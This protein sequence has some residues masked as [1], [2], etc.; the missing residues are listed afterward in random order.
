LALVAG[1]ALVAG[2]AVLWWPNGEYRPIQ[3]GERG[4]VAD[5]F[6]TIAE[7][8][9]GR[10]G[11]TE[12]RVKELG[13]A[14]ARADESTGATVPQ[15]SSTT[16]PASGQSPTTTARATTRTTDEVRATTT[17]SPTSSDGPGTGGSDGTTP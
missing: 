17:T 13:G 2:L 7:V 8:P 6:R 3:P 15:Q 14:P 9:T 16:T 1:A 12:E 11:L 4:T 5:A 10:P